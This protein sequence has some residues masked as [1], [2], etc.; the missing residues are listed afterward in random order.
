MDK[1]SEKWEEGLREREKSSERER[2]S[3]VRLKRTGKKPYR[4]I[5]ANKNN[6]TKKQQQRSSFSSLNPLLTLFSKDDFFSFILLFFLS[7][8]CLDL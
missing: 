8:V 2:A 5:K 1:V 7:F 6:N 4:F 3:C